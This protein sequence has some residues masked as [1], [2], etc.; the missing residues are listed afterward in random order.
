MPSTPQPEILRHAP[1]RAQ[2]WVGVR[3]KD[4]GWFPGLLSGPLELPSWRPQ[5]GP[6]MIPRPGRAL[7]GLLDT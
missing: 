6:V 2:R 7:K 4:Q 1:V 5:M 3:L